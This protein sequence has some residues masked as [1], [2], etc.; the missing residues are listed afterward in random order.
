MKRHII[1]FILDA[2]FLIVFNVCFFTL[3]ASTEGLPLSVWVSYGFIHLSFFLLLCTPL[4]VREGNR[5]SVD[6]RRPLYVGTWTYFV[7]VLIVNLA[8]I[9]VSLN[10]VLMQL[11]E[12]LH[13]SPRTGFRAWL[14]HLL[15]NSDGI[16]A[17]WL[18]KLLGTPISTE[19]AWIA[20]VILFAAAA[21]YLLVNMMVNNHTAEHQERHE[22]EALF[23]DNN[24]PRLKILVDNADSKTAE[25]AIEKTYYA[26]K[27]SPLRTCTEAKESEQKISAIIE[28]LEDAHSEEAVILLCGDINRLIQKRNR[29]IK[30]KK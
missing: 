5:A 21:V 11:F 28:Q 26:L 10:S 1:W 8:F 25:A 3:T 18:L 16:T 2:I 20:N 12:Q 23:V 30:E 7:V 22:Q 15:V 24:A 9:L 4:L 29:I 14:V 27:S 17:A 6:Y 19:A 13:L